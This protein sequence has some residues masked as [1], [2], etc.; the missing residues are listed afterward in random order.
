MICG[1][2]RIAVGVVGIVQHCGN[3]SFLGV[4]AVVVT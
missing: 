1:Q 2:R 3:L 4:V